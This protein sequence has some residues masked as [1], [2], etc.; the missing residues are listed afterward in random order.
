MDQ[1]SELVS[2]IIPTY[3]REQYLAEAIASV[4][5]QDYAPIELIVIDDGSSD[6]TADTVAPFADRLL[7]RLQENQGIAAARNAGVNLSHGQFLAFL[8]S[9]DIW[10]PGKLRLQMAVFHARPS[11]GVVYGHAR[12]FF[13]PEMTAPERARIRQQEGIFAAP[14]ASSLLVSRTT[15]ERVGPFDQSLNLSVDMDWYARMT[16]I[17]MDV[18]M[19][20]DV[21][22]LR[23]LH[24]TNINRTCAD[25]QIER[26]RLLKATL[27]RR[28]RMG[29][30]S[31]NPK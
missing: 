13:S 25:E 17:K 14:T 1:P 16:E 10:E 11:T 18:V 12:Q 2:V 6:G 20:P 8:D 23:R 9:D 31:A 24:Q 19:L 3:N 5:D 27:D 22:F 7:Y 21:L 29:K 15:F 30:N 28:R 4:L 26:V